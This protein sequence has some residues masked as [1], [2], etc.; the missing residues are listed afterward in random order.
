MRCAASMGDEAFLKLM[1]AI[2]AANTTKTVT[3][4]SFL[5]RRRRNVRVP[6][7]RRRPG[8]PGQRHRPPAATAVMVY[9]TV[10]DAGAN[11]YA[12]EQMQSRF[13]DQ[14]E[15]RVPV[16]KDFEVTRSLLRNHDVIF[17]GRPEA[18]S[19][20]AAWAYR[21]ELEYEGASFRIEGEMLRLRAGGAGAGGEEPARPGAH[22][23]GGGGQRCSAHCES[24]ARRSAR[25]VRDFR[26]R[27]PH[28]DGIHRLRRHR[29][30]GIRRPPP[31]MIGGALLDNKGVG[32]KSRQSLPG[33]PPGM[34]TGSECLQRFAGLRVLVFQFPEKVHHGVRRRVVRPVD[35]VVERLQLLGETRAGFRVG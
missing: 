16:Y 4:Q 13:F 21:L 28:A 29:G 17:V 7:A 1:D 18:N 5:D 25:G 8:L 19:A 6:R 27:P 2:F 3:A 32:S 20:L 14:F 33:L 31:P 9:G 35:Q 11:R 12:A 34:L 15:S 26:R 10:R 22:G 24:D 30:R 23:A